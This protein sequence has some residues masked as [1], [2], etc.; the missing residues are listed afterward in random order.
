MRLRIF[1]IAAA[2]AFFA[3]CGAADVEE[4]NGED[5]PGECPDGLVAVD[6]CPAFADCEVVPDCDGELLCAPP[7][8]EDPSNEQPNANAGEPV[9]CG[10]PMRCPAGT[11]EVD[12][13]PE[14][15][16]CTRITLC[17]ADLLCQE[18]PQMCVFEPLCPDDDRYIGDTCDHDAC[19][20]HHHC[21]GP[22]DCLRCDETVPE[23]CPEGTI[24]VD[25]D[26][27]D[28]RCQR[29]ETCDETLF[30]LSTCIENPVCLGNASRVDDC[31]DVEERDCFVIDGCQADLHCAAPPPPE[32]CDEEPTCPTGYQKAEV[33]QCLDDYFE[34]TIATQ[35]G[36]IAGCLPLS[37]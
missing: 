32:E 31:E 19:Y 5:C 30:C 7:P 8:E 27:S 4:P 18:A 16:V 15:A 6:I 26:D 9:D 29:V 37:E 21:S 13:C 3:A 33:D 35:C 34:C 36:Q 22:V 14:R 1:V 2:I 12:T 20:R 17:D 10:E 28:E 25:C 23:Q 11:L 24:A